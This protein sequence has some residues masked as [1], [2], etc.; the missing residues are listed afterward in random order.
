MPRDES[1]IENA[2]LTGSGNS[3]YA[4]GHGPQIASSQPAALVF[5]A[6]LRQNTEFLFLPSLL[7]LL[8]L[9]FQF[10]PRCA[11]A[12]TRRL[13]AIQH[14]DVWEII[15]RVPSNRITKIGRQFTMDLLND[16]KKRILQMDIR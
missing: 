5:K 3:G 2:A 14:Q 16:N 1:I 8:S 12:W 11:N 4:F 10:L 9:C 7:T 15:Q 6:M 13:D